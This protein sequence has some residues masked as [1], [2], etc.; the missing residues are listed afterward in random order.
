[1]PKVGGKKGLTRRPIVS[2]PK[3]LERTTSRGKEEKGEEI[4]VLRPG[5]NSIMGRNMVSGDQEKDLVKSR[6]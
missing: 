6:E 3:K 2:S 5:A 1:V 4:V